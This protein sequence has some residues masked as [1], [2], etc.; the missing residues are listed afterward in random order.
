MSEKRREGLCRRI[1]TV[2]DGK[3]PSRRYPEDVRQAVRS[4]VRGRL[5]SGKRRKE[6]CQELSLPI[7]TVRSGPH[8]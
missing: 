6:I 7:A 1:A 2:Q 3:P 4:F 8:P 5:A